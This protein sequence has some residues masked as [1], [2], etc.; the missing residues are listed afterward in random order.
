MK[1]VAIVQSNY[2][3]WRGYF[4]LIDS[5]DEFVLL[6][7]AQYTRR[8]WRNR[9]KIKTP[10]GAQ[11]LTIAVDVKGKYEQA[12]QDTRVA[13]PAWPEAHWQKVRQNYAKAAGFDE[14]GDFVREL[15][16]TVPSEMLSDVNHHFLTRI[17]ERLGITTPITWSRDYD[18]QGTKTDRLLGICVNAG[19]TEYVSGP[20]ARSY[21]EEERFHEKGMTVA[22]HEYGPFPDYEQVHPPFDPQVSVLD[23]LLNAGA[24]AR[25]LVLPGT[26]A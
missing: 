14:A 1:R 18:P 4:E 12:I 23:V 21:L 10:Q 26:R 9:N 20:A 2:V 3:P 6:D 15:Y 25:D 17:C 24:G 7:D 5:V 8:D 11:W 13:D 22:W 19:A 16:E